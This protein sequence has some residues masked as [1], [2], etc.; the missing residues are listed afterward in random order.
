[1]EARSVGAV[2]AKGDSESRR[3][4]QG[5]ACLSL[6][7]SERGR[8][9]VS[10]EHC[11]MAM[12]GAVARM[13]LP[14]WRARPCQ[15]KQAN[16]R[17]VSIQRWPKLSQMRSPLA[18]PCSHRWA[19]CRPHFTQQCLR[20][21]QP[22]DPTCTDHSSQKEQCYPLPDLIREMSR[23]SSRTEPRASAIRQRV[24]RTSPPPGTV[25]V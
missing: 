19:R 22:T 1:L 3:V 12:E 20:P 10:Q 7:V 5:K 8:S 17:R 11:F 13:R 2:K 9:V 25:G 4:V 6:T 15:T 24:S 21:S 16:V 14:F 18:V 23:R